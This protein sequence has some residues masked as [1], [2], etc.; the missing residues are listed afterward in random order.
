MICASLALAGEVEKA[1]AILPTARELH[2]RLSIDWA[3]ANVPYQTPHLMER[4]IDGLRK[5]GLGE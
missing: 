4:Y 3:R 5:A 2:P 1:R